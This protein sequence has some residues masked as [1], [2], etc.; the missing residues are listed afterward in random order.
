MLL[1]AGNAALSDLIVH[2]DRLPSSASV[3]RIIGGPGGDGRW[4]P[5]GSALTVAL[6][7]RETGVPVV[8]WHPLPEVATAGIDLSALRRAGV[9]LGRCPLVA[10]PPGRCLIVEAADERLCWSTDAIPDLVIDPNLLVGIT[11]V[12][13]CPQWGTWSSDLLGLASERGIACSLVGEVP[14]AAATFTW[15]TVVADWRQLDQAPGLRAALV[16][17]TRGAAGVDL[18]VGNVTT[19]VP[20]VPVEPVEFDRRRRCL[21][22]HVDRT[23]A[24]RRAGA[25][26]G[27]PRL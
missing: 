18:H 12:V 10:D 4:L 14:P 11:H 22:R 3:G 21:F 8:L 24:A 20:T 6:A 9:E 15:D 23:L 17:A 16:A 13:F 7:A 1:V 25:G 2:V 27:R 19:H 26:S 5:G